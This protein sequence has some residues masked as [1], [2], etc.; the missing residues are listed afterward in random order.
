MRLLLD[1]GPD[2]GEC[3]PVG[4]CRGYNGTC[5][6][7]ATQFAT[8]AVMPDYPNGLQDWTCTSFPNDENSVDTFIVGLIALAVSLPVTVFIATCFEIANDNEAPESWLEWAGWRKLVFG[9]NAHRRWHYTRGAPPVRYVKWYVRSAGAPVTETF[10]NLC[11]SGYAWATGGEPFWVTEAREAAEEAHKEV[12][13]AD[14]CRESGGGSNSHKSESASS[15]VRSAMAFSVYK[16]HVMLLGVA[17]TIVCWALF[18]WRA[19]TPS[20]CRP[21]GSFAR[22]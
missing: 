4:D 11:R 9:L 1:S 6:L 10:A 18:T 13:E 19:P 15:S 21:C 22:N 3:P 14:A 8:V 16:R 2:G 5:G 7:L 17:A 20:R 12:C